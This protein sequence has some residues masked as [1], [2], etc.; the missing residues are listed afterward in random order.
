MKGIINFVIKNKLAVWLLVIILIGSGVYS[1]FKMKM[2]T[3]PD[4]SIP[5]I[6]VMTIYPGA[7][8]EQVMNEVS[9]P[10]EKAVTNLK[11]VS[12]VY[13]T[14]IS[15]MSNVQIEYEYGTNMAEAEREIKSVLDN[16]LLPETAQDPAVARITINAFPV[17]AFSVSSDMEDIVALTATVEEMILPKIEGIDGVSTVSI[18]GQHIQEIE[19]TLNERKMSSLGITEDDVKQ[20]IRASDLRMPLGLYPF[21]EKEQS[22][23]IDGKLTT[24]KALAQLLVPV[25]PSLEHPYPFIGLGDIST[26]EMVGKV[27]SISRTNGKEAIAVQIVKAQDANTV[28]VVN[29]AKELSEELEET[30]EGLNIDITLDQGAPIEESVETMLSKAL[31]GAGFAILII[32]LFL[33]DLKSTIISV[34]SI[35]LS[36]FIALTVL[37]Y[38]DI[39]LNMMTLGA[40][41]IAIGRVID[42][43]I[44]VVENIYRRIHL[45]TE[46]LKGQALIRAATIEM[47]KP[48]L[49]STLVTVAVFAPLVFVSGMVGELFL[50]FALT[51]T[52]ALLASL[53]IAITVVPM[54]SHT[55]FQNKLYLD[56]TVRGHRST[57]SL[58]A[59]Y[60]KRVL[61]WSLNHK[62]LTFVFSIILLVASLL[63]I[64]LVGFS[65][66]PS[67][68]QKMMYITYTPEP[69]EAEAKTIENISVV[70]RKLLR[71]DDVDVVQ[72]SLGGNGNAMMSAGLDGALMYVI[73]DP[74]IENF[75][76]VRSEVEQYI[77]Q[78]EQS[79]TWKSQ[80][81]AISPSSNELRYIIYGDV[82][83][84][85]EEVIVQVEA[86]MKE[87]GNLKDISSSL[88]ERYDEFTLK[89]DQQ[90][91]LQYGLTSVQIAAMLN[92]NIPEEAVTT[93]EI[94]GKDVEVIIQ[95]NKDVA[96]SF[97]ELLNKQ[98]PTPLGVT[99][100]L[101][102]IVEVVEGTVSNTISRS[103]GQLYA[104]V[105]GAITTKDV[106]KASTEVEA[107][108]QKL[109]LP[110]GVSI[111]AAGVDADMKEA[112][113]QLG[114]AML[115]AIAVVYFI[116]VVTFGEGLAPFAILFSLPFTVIGALTALW[117]AGETISVSAMMGVLM[118][119]GIVVTNAI[120]LV[121]RIIHM[122][123]EGVPLR[124]AILEAGAIR[125]RPILMTAIATIGALI[126]LAIGAEG[127]GLISKGLGI[128]VIGGLLSSTILTLIVVPIVYELL[129]NLFKKI[130]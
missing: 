35:P 45:K 58:L 40:M 63:L 122:E 95:K 82:L 17:V 52:L 124:E 123:Y 66:I 46:L 116:L 78:L 50:P 56:N 88:S 14:S 68:E 74:E 75:D 113:T 70:E 49:S 47:F 86:I 30:I 23:V 12:S 21:E 125:L 71:R 111:E 120:V 10:M 54:L 2:E 102:D 26:I 38:V 114:L 121:D 87:S 8:P 83:D 129:S 15:N 20:I 90:T 99:V 37:Y 1:A 106:T 104:S 103:E 39:T 3:I 44:V 61:Q 62:F 32:L 28:H 109:A 11:G 76:A 22:V 128:T 55:L 91:L 59:K 81:F 69:G 48:I 19:L 31:F 117:L 93:I 96:A 72:V 67:D 60:Y 84:E 80:N 77:T 29:E 100:R 97:D 108:L 85:L 107:K 5:V 105:S 36:L 126:P 51:V 27:E 98:V 41:T 89:A 73:F 64:P 110:K 18:T 115:A 118:L 25:T 42:D 53:I 9:I 101:G 112:F 24:T 79:G 65:F 4:I 57:K 43:S 34:I 7:T 92:P 94:D 13:S 119:I 127:G 6:T 16:V 33:R 130:R